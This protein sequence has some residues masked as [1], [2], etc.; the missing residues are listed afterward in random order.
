MKHFMR[1]CFLFFLAI[2]LVGCAKTETKTRLDENK[3]T[4]V[5]K[6]LFPREMEAAWAHPTFVGGRETS[7]ATLV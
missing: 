5:A 3:T 1:W 7:H 6:K 4:T 2:P